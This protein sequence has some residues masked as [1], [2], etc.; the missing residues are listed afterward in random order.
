MTVFASAPDLSSVE[1]NFRY[2]SYLRPIPPITITSESACRAMRASSSLYGSPARAKIGSFCDFTSVLKRSII[3]MLVRTISCGMMRLAGFT[4][5]WPIGELSPSTAGPPSR[6]APV[7]VNARPRRS[8]ENGTCIVS[9]RNL[10]FADV[11]TPRAPAK[12]CRVT[13]A[14]S[15]L[16]TCARE[17]PARD[18]ISAISPYLTSSA[19][20]VATEPDRASIL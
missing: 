7:P 8:L 14:P 4:D 6:G 13:L 20:S 12:I 5:G 18:S 16:I 3:G 15:S 1:R 2:S 19:R 9:P 10:T 11:S 17:V